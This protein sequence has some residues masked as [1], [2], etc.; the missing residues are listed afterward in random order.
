M[1]Y[2]SYLILLALAGITIHS[3]CQQAEDP[4]FE[5]TVKS[6]RVIETNN[7]FGLELLKTVF[8]TEEAPNIMIS[9][10]SVSLALGMA[11]N[12]A[13]TTTMDAFEQVLDY[14]GLTREEVNKIS[15]ELINVLVTNVE[16]NLLEIANSLWYDDGFPV[17]QGFI[18]LNRNYYDAQVRAL[19]FRSAEAVKTINDWVS[20]KTHGKI[21]EIIRNIDPA[22]MVILIN[23][24]YF[25]CVWEVK[26]DPDDTRPA[27]FYNEDGS[28]WEEV[29]M[30]KLEST[31]NAT[32][33]DRY[34]GVELPYKNGKF[35]MYL[36]LPAERVT[37]NELAGTLDAEMWKVW[38][39]GF[40]EIK[41]FTVQMPKFKFEYERSL[42]D[43]L[44][45][46]GLQVA[47]TDQADFSGISP[48]HLQISDV[49]HKTYIDVNEEGTEA[50][51]V[52]AIMFE[53]TALKPL[54]IIRL[55]RPFLF[56][57]TETSSQSILFMG[58]VSRPGY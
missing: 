30:M 47:F 35:S 28:L 2:K 29:D 41:D 5:Y 53:N 58:K 38:L 40:S 18:D 6:A 16:G 46:I 36:F 26:F 10:A 31:F 50:A 8:S 3:G 13:G 37:V 23:A 43:D 17:E 34:S 48:E 1:K 21:D 39:A 56:A 51:A 49:I 20:D 55:D 54:S 57:I 33:T 32:F 15:Q 27:P 24:I 25:N 22:V 19:D 52:T 12:G 11:Y 7:Q 14:D 45:A 42:S 9:P 44:K 4:V